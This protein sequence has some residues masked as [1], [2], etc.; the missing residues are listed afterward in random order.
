MTETETTHQQPVTPEKKTGRNGVLWGT[1]FAAIAIVAIITVA[2]YVTKPDYV[3]E[4]ICAPCE[5]TGEV[6]RPWGFQWL[7]LRDCDN[8]FGHGKISSDR[9]DPCKGT[10]RE[11]AGGWEVTIYP[12]AIGHFGFPIACPNCDG[13][14]RRR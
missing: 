6:A 7:G 9:C 13:T 12:P 1:L 4:I 5:G 8:C 11:R 14:G 10:G 3:G 2:Y